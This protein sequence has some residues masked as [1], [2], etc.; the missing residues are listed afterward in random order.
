MTEKIFRF[1]ISGYG[2]AARMHADAVRRAGHIVVGVSGPRPGPRD[3]FSQANG[4]L[5][6]VE[7]VDEL[8]HKAN[9]DALIVCSPNAIHFTDAAQAIAAGVHVLIEKPA[10]TSLKDCEALRLSASAAN[11]TVGV[12]HMWRYRDEVISMRERV[13][14]GEFGSIVRTHGYGVH[15]RWGPSGWF[16][17]REL[18]GGGALIDMGIHAIDTAR[19]ILGDPQPIRVQAS[20]GTGAF[21]DVNVDDDGLIIIDWDNGVRSLIECGWWQPV[22]GG[23]EAETKVIGT[24][25]HAQIW[26]AFESFGDKYQHCD[27]AMYEAQI[28]DFVNSCMTGVEPRASFS[29]GQVAL[30]IVLQAYESAGL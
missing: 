23:I 21:S 30:Q 10:T 28:R 9:L 1:G 26:P 29:V 25:G 13:K 3:I 2:W 14:S 27:V 16:V 15:A 24:H 12:G 7:T 11:V 19:F 17:N 20:L 22:L 6:S 18:S 4:C 5:F 8:V